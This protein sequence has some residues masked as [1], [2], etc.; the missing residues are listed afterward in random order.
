MAQ[1]QQKRRRSL[2]ERINELLDEV[3]TAGPQFSMETIE[4]YAQEAERAREQRAEEQGKSGDILGELVFTKVK[5]ERRHAEA[6]MTQE[7]LEETL[8]LA[9]GLEHSRTREDLRRVLEQW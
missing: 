8:T 6:P 3:F 1:T 5:S 9:E 4:K 2:A 7:A